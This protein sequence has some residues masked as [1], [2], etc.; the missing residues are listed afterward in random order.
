[1]LYTKF[2]KSLNKFIKYNVINGT[3]TKTIKKMF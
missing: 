3:V 2:I 1:M